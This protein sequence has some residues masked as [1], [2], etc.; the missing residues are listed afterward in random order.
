MNLKVLTTQERTDPHHFDKQHSA[1]TTTPP[2]LLLKAITF[3]FL[4]ILFFYLLRKEPK[5][6]NDTR[7]NRTPTLRLITLCLDH[8][9]IVIIDL[10]TTVTGAESSTFFLLTNHFLPLQEEPKSANDTRRNRSPTLRLATPGLDH[11]TTVTTAGGFH[12]FF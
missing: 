12:F 6:V 11:Y 4:L 10:D 7:R 2:W 5:S 1:L 3:F 9:T 8:Y